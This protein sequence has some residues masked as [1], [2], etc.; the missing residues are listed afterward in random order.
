MASE[1]SKLKKNLRAVVKW[2]IYSLLLII[3]FVISQTPNVL[4]FFGVRAVLILPLTLL[5]AIF[6]GEF[7]GGIY[8]ACAGMLWGCSADMVFGYYSIILL[9]LAVACALIAQYGLSVSLFSSLLL[10]AGSAVILFLL[11]F[12][13]QYAIWGYSGLSA[14]FV[15]SVLPTATVTILFT[16]PLYF[17]VKFVSTRLQEPK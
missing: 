1:S 4:S 2:F 16:I 6:E 13:F 5:V 8:A 17:V 15:R 7:A 3:L 14:L 10:S 12:F 9:V 11:D